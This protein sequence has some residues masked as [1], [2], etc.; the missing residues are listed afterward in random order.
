MNFVDRAAAS[1]VRGAE[2]LCNYIQEGAILMSQPYFSITEQASQN[3]IITRTIQ[4]TSNIIHKQT[5]FELKL[6]KTI[7]TMDITTEQKITKI[8]NIINATSDATTI[9]TAPFWAKHVIT[10][11]KVVGRLVST[12]GSVFWALPLWA[13]ITFVSTTTLLGL[14]IYIYYRYV[15]DLFSFFQGLV[16]TPGQ[17]RSFFKTK[18]WDSQWSVKFDIMPVDPVDQCSDKRPPN[19]SRYF[20]KNAEGKEVEV[21]DTTEYLM[22]YDRRTQN[23]TLITLPP[24]G[25][26]FTMYAYDGSIYISNSI[27]GWNRSTYRP[28]LITK[29]L[30]S[31][32][33][34]QALTQCTIANT[35]TDLC[36]YL[37]L[38]LGRSQQYNVSSTEKRYL[39]YA[40]FMQHIYTISSIQSGLMQIPYDHFTVS[41][42]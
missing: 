32:V 17:S 33:M 14:G 3:A 27:V 36:E 18:P 21:F 34:E 10:F 30:P 5:Q 8:L 41:K 28:K 31:A 37:R 22:P 35:L 7:V 26:G 24:L 40:C 1:F 12:V 4:T 38:N 2:V 16:R 9:L 15:R 23:I 19:Y 39:V 29:E 11:V 6:I 20:I 42:L 13:K 25:E